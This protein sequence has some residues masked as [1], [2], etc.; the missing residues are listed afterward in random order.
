MGV[1]GQLGMGVKDGRLIHGVMCNETGMIRVAR[2]R[3]RTRARDKRKYQHAFKSMTTSNRH[4]EMK[5]R[6]KEHRDLAEKN[7]E[8]AANESQT[9]QLL[10]DPFIGG[11]LG[12]DRT[13]PT[14]VL[15]AADVSHGSWTKKEADYAIKMR[16][17][18]EPKDFLLVEAKSVERTLDDKDVQQLRDYVS[19]SPSA[20]FGLLT[21]GVDYLWFKC[22][23]KM[24]TMEDSPFLKHCALDEPSD[25]TSEWLAAVSKGSSVLDELEKL[26]SRMSLEGAILAWLNSIF[27]NPGLKEAAALNKAASLGV[28][29][30]E[31]ELV[32]EAAR[33]VWSNLRSEPPRTPPTPPTSSQVDLAIVLEPKL[34]L[35]DGEDL[36]S[37]NL[38]RAWRIG[39]EPWREMPNASEL[40][41]TVL[42]EILACDTRR[43]DEERLAEELNLDF[44][45]SPPQGTR[46]SLIDG[47]SSLYCITGVSN[48]EKRKLLERIAKDVNI[49]P[50]VRHPVTQGKTIECWLPTGGP[51]EKKGSAS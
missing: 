41:L 3:C 37:E 6:L 8:Y 12:Y 16:I 45:E 11:V 23:P 44:F 2:H 27:T 14:E 43:K 36:N 7:R 25:R 35:E 13:D 32:Q 31:L 42:R 20:R 47:F 21:N 46:Y 9:R 4:S 5:E 30:S 39:T 15:E 29:R 19:G 33:V 28:A 40:I 38:P 1:G 18:G 10:I 22:P 34:V 51:R 17:N 24:R 50:S 49:D 26:A 48:S